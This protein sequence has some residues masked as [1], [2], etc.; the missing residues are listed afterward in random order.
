MDADGMGLSSSCSRAVARRARLR[1]DTRTAGRH[2][3]IRAGAPCGT[4][5]E[6]PEPASGGPCVALRRVNFRSMTRSVDLT[7]RERVLAPQ[8]ATAEAED[9]HADHGESGRLGYR[10][11]EIVCGK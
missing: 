4:R 1:P 7:S 11:V 5:M 2:R 3:G 8:H 6:P 9:A 10:D